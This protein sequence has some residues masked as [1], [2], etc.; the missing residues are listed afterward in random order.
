M[1]NLIV[2]GKEHFEKPSGAPYDRALKYAKAVIAD[3]DT[4]V[5]L[6]SVHMPLDLELSKARE[7]E[8]SIYVVGIPA[9]DASRKRGF[10]E[11]TLLATFDPRPAKR[12]MSS[13]K[14][15]LD[16]LEGETTILIWSSAYVINHTVYRT[17]FKKWG[18]RVIVEANEV[19]L[20]IAF[21]RPIPAGLPKR[22]LFFAMYPAIFL[23]ALLNDFSN[24][25]FDGAIAISTR[26]KRIA[27][28]LKCPS[29]RVPILS[30]EIQDEPPI[31]VP[32]DGPLEL[33]FT[34]AISVRKEGLL[35]LFKA[36]DK[37][38]QYPFRLNLYGYGDRKSQA[39]L[40]DFMKKRQLQDR[41]VFHGLVP[42]SEIPEI[43]RSQHLLLLPR[44]SNVQTEYGFAT[45]LGSY[46]ASGVPVLL[47]D[48]SDNTL[49][50]KDGESALIVPPGDIEQLYLKLKWCFEHRDKLSCIGLKGREVA[51]K[52]FSYQNFIPSLSEFIFK[53]DRT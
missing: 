23:E 41:I 44:P 47:T 24:Y 51:Q 15:F 53:Q 2:L 45:K 37:L 32:Q 36:L 8:P 25:R 42:M 10:L 29:I 19:Q 34:G 26:I 6:T 31:T 50:L 16:Q 52:S 9:N 11:R 35:N 5:F 3:G 43:L 22:V 13:F 28:R 14:G 1:K 20:G 27:D 40:T 18:Y 48:I 4:R 38:K 46:L 39:I 7:I 33:G 30:D 12:F 17:A 21:N 49:Y